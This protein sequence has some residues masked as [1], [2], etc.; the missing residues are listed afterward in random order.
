MKGTAEDNNVWFACRNACQLD[1]T[2][3]RFC[4]RVAKEETV[5]RRR[6]NFAQFLDQPQHGLMDDNIRLRMQKKP[7]LLA[8]RFNNLR[9][10]VACIRHTNTAG[11]VKQFFAVYCVD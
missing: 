8:N 5:N 1:G 7:R 6:R 9:M 4:T 3:Y 2:L 11:E 10:T